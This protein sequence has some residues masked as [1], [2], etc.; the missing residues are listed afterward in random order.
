MDN[1]K[2]A[3]LIYKLSL[4]GLPPFVQDSVINN[5]EKLSDQDIDKILLALDNLSKREDDYYKAANRY[6]E[7]FSSLVKRIEKKQKR[8]ITKILEEVEQ[9][10]I[11]NTIRVKN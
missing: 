10:L 6:T 9:E 4:S 1:T 7:F 11:R 2:I 3:K 5:L 8:E